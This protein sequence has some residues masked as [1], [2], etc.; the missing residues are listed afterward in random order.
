MASPIP[1]AS[2]RQSSVQAVGQFTATIINASVS[3]AGLNVSIPI[4]G[5]KLEETF[6]SSAQMMDTS[7]RVPLID[8]STAGLVNAVTAGILTFRCV[9]VGQS[10][11]SGDLPTISSYIQKGGD[12]LG[13]SIIITYTFNG[14]TET[15]T[16]TGCLLVHTPPLILAGN[17]VAV[18]EIAFSYDDYARTP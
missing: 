4:R 13:S 14:V 9:R 16:F 2:N 7:K 8:G 12:Q 15:W 1:G 10:L 18:Y 17:D 11:N 5:I 6:L 3:L